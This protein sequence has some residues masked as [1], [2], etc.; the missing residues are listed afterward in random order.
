[1]D[2]RTEP[3]GFDTNLLH[4]MMEPGSYPHAPEEVRHIQTHIS[5]VFIAPPYV[6]KFKKPVDFGFLDYST[7]EKRR[8]FCRREVQLN[9]RLTDGI[10]LGVIGI[11]RREGSYAMEAADRDADLDAFVEYAVKMQQ[12]SDE[13]F[14]DSY[15]QDNRLTHQRL[16]RVADRLASFYTDQQQ[17]EDLSE[18]GAIEKI[19][20]NTDENFNQTKRFIGQTI[21]REAFEAIR[22]YTH[23]YYRVHEALFQKRREEG[24]IVDGHGDLHLEHIYITPDKVMVYDCIEFND[25]FRYGDLASDLAFLAMDLDFKGCWREQRYFVARMAE[26][27]D[28][29]DLERIINFYKCYRA[30]VKG[31]VKSLQSTEEEVPSEERAQA[32]DLASRYFSLSL[33]YALL[34]SDVVA[35]IFMGRVG[36]GKSTLSR[37]FSD[38]LNIK[39]FSSDHIRKRSMDLPLTERTP[40]SKR[41]LLYSEQVSERTYEK[42][43]EEA[44]GSEANSVILDATY[45][46]KANRDKLVAK[47]ESEGR[48]YVFVE[49]RCPDETIKERLQGRENQGDV[50]SDA[51]LE[52]F[53]KLSKAYEPPAEVRDSHIISVSTDQS[54]EASVGELYTRLAERNLKAN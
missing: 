3:S 22:H 2:D 43:G 48:D 27:L 31:K 37:K 23:A 53:D 21:E 40:D 42:L 47:L 24:R 11:A 26:K 18:W 13:Y 12:L 14:L 6:Y 39:R 33:S 7:L 38:M 9:R 15:I 54:I 5:H 32:A 16:D 4:F 50:V 36:T 46:K 49:A 52:D 51:R 45:S 19:K 41:V 30:Y 10:Y 17:D 28:D 8:K 25:R 35:V 34:G 29:H 1:M 44:A 20:V